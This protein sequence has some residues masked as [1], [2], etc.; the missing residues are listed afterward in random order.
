MM[1]NTKGDNSS[2]LLKT[3]VDGEMLC[4]SGR[5]DGGIIVGSMSNLQKPDSVILVD[6]HCS[7]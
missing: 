4:T 2:D 1:W 7:T 5:F 3:P 6:I